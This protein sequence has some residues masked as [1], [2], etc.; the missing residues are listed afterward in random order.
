MKLQYLDLLDKWI[1]YGNKDLWVSK[2]VIFYYLGS[3][4]V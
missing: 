1:L 3:N 2:V 4:V